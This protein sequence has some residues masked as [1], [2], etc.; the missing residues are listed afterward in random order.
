VHIYL[1]H[2]LLIETAEK[3]PDKQAVVLNDQS[4][5]FGELEAKSNQLAGALK[6]LNVRKGDRVGI[7]FSK[8]IE[9]IIAAFSVLKAGATYVPIDPTAPAERAK[10]IVSNC[11]IKCL[12]TS[13]KKAE[14]ILPDLCENSELKSALVAGNPD[15][16]LKQ[17]NRLLELIFW[18]DIFRSESDNQQLP[19]ITDTYPAY[20]LYTSGSTGIP[21]GVVISHLNSLQWV[22]MAAHFFGIS[23]DDILSNHPPLHFDMSVFDIFTAVKCGATIVLI[24]EAYS[25]FPIKMAEC[26]KQN[27]IS[28]WNSVPT[29]L[30]L[31][32]ERVEL[33]TFNFDSLRLV[34]FAGSILPVKHLRKLMASAPNAKFFNIYGQ[35]EANSSTFFPINGIPK[36]DTWKIPIGQ[37]FPN[38]EVLA[39]D[40]QG[41]AISSAQEEG[42]LYVRGSTVA[43]GY[44]GDRERTSASFLTDPLNPLSPTKVYKTGD[45]VRLDKDENYTFIGRRDHMVKSKGYRIEMDEIEITLYSYPGIKQAVVVALPDEII[46]NKIIAYVAAEDTEELKEKE[47]LNHCAKK[48]PKYMIPEKI[49]CRRRLPSTSSGK[50]DRNLLKKEAVSDCS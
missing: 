20:I 14:S 47:L 1:L 43:M 34:L 21:K 48:L 4:L 42:E 36:D 38:F 40:E 39:L 11:E 28:I 50:I 18:E 33:D 5:T 8:S 6:R 3:Y 10:Y 15:A 2:H 17:Q 9:S 49:F 23:P 7:L 26:I 45:L 44:W 16:E 32:A 12:L 13:D 25:I 46:G 37:A 22:D 31:L 41:K 29:V 19:D 24:P 30:S 27:Q 35:T